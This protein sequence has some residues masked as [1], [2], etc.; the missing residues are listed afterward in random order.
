K[1]K[2]LNDDFGDESYGVGIRKG[3]EE[4]LEKLNQAFED[5]KKDGTAKK[6]SE[7]WFGQDI[8]K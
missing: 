5:M 2:I 1:Y 6:I 4:L 3:D 7:K 8:F